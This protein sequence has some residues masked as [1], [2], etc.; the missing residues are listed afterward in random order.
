MP[1]SSDCGTVCLGS[2]CGDFYGKLACSHLAL[3]GCGSGCRGCCS[4]TLHERLWPPPI[5]PPGSMSGV[6]QSPAAPLPPS[7]PPPASFL[8][9]P[10]GPEATDGVQDGAPRGELPGLHP[11]MHSTTGVKVDGG[12]DAPVGHLTDSATSLDHPR[13]AA[14]APHS[15]AIVGLS[16]VVVLGGVLAAVATAR[17]R[18]HAGGRLPVQ[19]RHSRAEID[20]GRL[21]T[22]GSEPTDDAELDQPQ[23]LPETVPVDMQPAW[24]WADASDEVDLGDLVLGID[25]FEAHALPPPARFAA[26][27]QPRTPTR[28]YL[29]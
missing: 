16:I 5:A 9:P 26:Q 4:L 20:M 21:I 14:A 27:E 22:D 11:G 23:S 3:L 24:Q 29:D 19:T 1:I 13:A 12:G 10:L 7:S 25:P 17:A 28:L 18:R 15:S 8:P 6:Y 2:T